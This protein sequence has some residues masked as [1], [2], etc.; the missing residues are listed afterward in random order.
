MSQ[1]TVAINKMDTVGWSSDR[2]EE[3]V[4][5]LAQFLRLAGFKETDIAYIPCSG[6]AGENLTASPT[7]AA[8]AEWYRGP[9]LVHQIGSFSFTSP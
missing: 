5:K 3:I 2:Y 1:L 9:T 7:V 6:L 4:K 8:L